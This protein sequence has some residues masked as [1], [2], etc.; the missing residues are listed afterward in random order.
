MVMFEAFKKYYCPHCNAPI[1]MY[2]GYRPNE[3]PFCGGIIWYLGG[4][5]TMKGWF[6]GPNLSIKTIDIIVIV[7]LLICPFLLHIIL[8][9][10]V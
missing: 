1:D 4:I 3:C 5:R 10:L 6:K 9:R 2:R 8:K 7:L